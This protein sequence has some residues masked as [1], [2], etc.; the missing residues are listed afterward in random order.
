MTFHYVLFINTNASCHRYSPRTQLGKEEPT[1]PPRPSI[2]LKS[3]GKNNRSTRIQSLQ[4]I[5]VL[6]SKEFFLVEQEN[7]WCGEFNFL[8]E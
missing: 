2:S 3:N 5:P 4:S 7:W 1:L 6:F 8:K